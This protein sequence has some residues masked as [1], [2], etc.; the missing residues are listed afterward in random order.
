MPV[1]LAQRGR[2][3]RRPQMPYGINWDSPQARGL[4]AWWTMDEGV[5]IDHLAGY[6]FTTTVGAEIR[7]EPDPFGRAYNFGGTH[8]MEVAASTLALP[9]YPFS[10][11]AW[12]YPNN[13]TAAHVIA[14]WNAGAASRANL[15]FRGDVANDPV[16]AQSVNSAGTAASA[17]STSAYRAND[18]NHALGVWAASNDRRAYVN[19][20]GKGTT[21]TDIAL[22]GIS[23][24]NLGTQY[25]SGARVNFLDGRV[26]DV[27]LY[28]RALAD[29]EAREAWDP[30]TRWDLYWMPSARAYLFLAAVPSGVDDKQPM[31]RG[32]DRGMDR[33]MS[34]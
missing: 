31:N 23:F 9:S 21:T 20:A 22:S 24:F 28:A 12:V 26:A 11:S 15:V 30:Q 3:W 19:G 5:V 7:Q 33:G 13:I 29:A 4:I 27:R 10:M 14:G 32:F 18:W 17:L 6:R 8:Y 2:Q 16:A 34:A 25:V 1:Y